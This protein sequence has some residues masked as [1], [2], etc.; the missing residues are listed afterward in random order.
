MNGQQFLD[1]D[2]GYS[3]WLAANPDGYVINAERKPRPTYVMLHRATCSTISGMPAR[4]R[5]WTK[6][7]LKFCA[8]SRAEAEAWCVSTVGRGPKPCGRCVGAR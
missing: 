2:A 1:D 8:A 7:Y 5:A 6:D 4:G 3:A